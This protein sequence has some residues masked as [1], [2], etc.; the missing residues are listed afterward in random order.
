M[1]DSPKI[2]QA[3]PPFRRCVVVSAEP[4]SPRLTRITLAGDELDDLSIDAPAASVRL[5]IPAPGHDLVVPTWNG[6]EFLLPD[7]SRPIIRT[8]T[9]RALDGEVLTIDIVLHAEGAMSHWA[10]SARGGEHAAISGTGRGYTIDP[11][12][13]GLLLAGD[14]SAIPAMSQLLEWIPSETTVRAVIEVAE[15]KGRTPIPPHPQA[16]VDWVDL[17]AGS[18]PGDAMVEAV[19]S[20]KIPDNWRVWAAGEAAAMFRIRKH[21]FDTL[22]LERRH[23]TVRGYW[24]HGRSGPG[25]T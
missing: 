13:D 14:E 4:L 23:A 9:P 22:G 17:Q 21:L 10:A 20:M 16:T 7:G 18:P 24:K 25:S 5:L 1:T 3:P 11:G 8:L 2:R 15:P 6:N 19:Q 12:A